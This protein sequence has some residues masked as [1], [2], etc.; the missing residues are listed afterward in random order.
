MKRAFIGDIHGDVESFKKLYYILLAKGVD[1]VWHCGDLVDRGPDSHGVLQ[2]CIQNKIPGVLGN[3]DEVILKHW[4]SWKKSKFDPAKMP[5]RNPDK[6]NTLKQLTQEDIEYL[7]SLPYMHVFDDIKTIAI[8]G[9]MHYKL[10]LWQHKGELLSRYQMIC[11]W[12]PHM[13]KWMNKHRDGTPEEKLRE[14]GWVRWYEV[15]DG[16]YNVVFGHTVFKDVLVHK[17]E[18]GSYCI[19]VDTGAVF[20]MKM[21][22]VILPDM[23]VVE[24]LDTPGYATMKDNNA[25]F[26]L[27]KD[28][29]V[30]GSDNKIKAP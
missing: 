7:K 9:G 20:G 30:V 29:T 5:T 23:T 28:E 18:V 6:Q 16:E 3:H 15:W 2:F 22:A 1:E 8:H 21:S 17:T 14:E 13:S 25:G 26:R 11:P 12:K 24:V 27:T 19:G 4:S 10:E